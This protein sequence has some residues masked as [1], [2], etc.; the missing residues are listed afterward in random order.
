[1]SD[2]R[3]LVRRRVRF[4]SIAELVEAR[5]SQCVQL[6]SSGVQPD[7]AAGGVSEGEQTERPVHLVSAIVQTSP[8]TMTECIDLKPVSNKELFFW[9]TFVMGKPC[10]PP[11]RPEGVD[12]VESNSRV[13]SR[14][15]WLTR[16]LDEGRTRGNLRTVNFHTPFPPP[17]SEY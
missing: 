16:T 3:S 17:Q 11:P 1:M 13:E 9:E 8:P 15:K 6:V 7:D 4:C 12:G 10:S 2:N 5:G 14:E